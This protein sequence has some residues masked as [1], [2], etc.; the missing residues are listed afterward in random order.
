MAKRSQFPHNE[1]RATYRSHRNG[2]GRCGSGHHV[3]S[4]GYA[5]V[6]TV[7]VPFHVRGENDGNENDDQTQQVCTMNGKL[8]I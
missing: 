7:V 1:L 3:G 8:D 2:S 4:T 5:A 6:R